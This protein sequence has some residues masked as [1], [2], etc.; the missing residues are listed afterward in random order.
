MPRR[1][2]VT[3]TR[4]NRSQGRKL[5]TLPIRRNGDEAG[6]NAQ[7]PVHFPAGSLELPG[8]CLYG[9]TYCLSYGVVLGILLMGLM[10]PGRSIIGKAMLDATGTA[11]RDLTRFR[12]KRLAGRIAPS[13]ETKDLSTSRGA[14]SGVM[15]PVSINSGWPAQ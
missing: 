9:M 1:T 14:G 6:S 15:K 8:K 4:R 5:N 3:H 7:T 11:R 13:R 10:I 12:R 2:S